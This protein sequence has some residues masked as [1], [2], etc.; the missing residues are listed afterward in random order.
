L[1]EKKLLRIA[2]E[3]REEKR[4]EEFTLTGNNYRFVLVSVL[5][6][7]SPSLRLF[8]FP[9]L[10]LSRKKEIKKEKDSREGAGK[11]ERVDFS[12]G[13]YFIDPLHLTS[14]LYLYPVNS[15]NPPPP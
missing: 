7:G 10:F 4:R 6:I 9:L 15:H 3:R 5:S 2:K 14:R 13:D 12:R 11:R 8:S 1:Q